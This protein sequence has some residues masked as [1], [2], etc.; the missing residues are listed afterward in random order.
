MARADCIDLSRIPAGAGYAER[1]GRCDEMR[2]QA[3]IGAAVLLA[4]CASPAARIAEVLEQRGLDAPRARCIGARLDRDLSVAQLRQLAAAARAYDSG[5]G[6][7]GK[8]TAQ[9]LARIASQ[10]PDPAVPA[11]LFNAGRSCGIG[12]ADLLG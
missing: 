4:S 7:T 3:I 2:L 9:D 6:A 11:A 1:G 12:I 8:M 5:P 10:V